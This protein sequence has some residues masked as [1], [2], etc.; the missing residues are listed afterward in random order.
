M[1]KRF[2]PERVVKKAATYLAEDGQ[3]KPTAAEMRLLA[4]LARAM[5]DESDRAYVAHVVASY[6]E[7]GR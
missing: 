6:Q 5:C 7:P 3:G 4:A 1:F 2:D